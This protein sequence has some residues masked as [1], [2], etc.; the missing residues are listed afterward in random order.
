M[1]VTIAAIY[2]NGVLK[3]QHPLQLADGSHVEV[4]INPSV[5]L[6]AWSEEGE[7]RRRALIDK[8][9]AGTITAEELVELE[10]LDQLANEQFDRIAPPPVHAAR[11]LHDRLLTERANAH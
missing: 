5:G 4:T 1:S 9:I 7:T 3:P 8:D 2:E 6:A 11:R 10:R